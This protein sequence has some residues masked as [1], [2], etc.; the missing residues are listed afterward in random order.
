[1]MNKKLIDFGR[2]NMSQEVKTYTLE[3]FWELSEPSDGSKLELIEGILYMTPP[4]E[5]EHDIVATRINRV[6]TIELVKIKNKGRIYVPRAAIWTSPNNFLEPDLFYLSEELEKKIAHIGK[7][8]GLSHNGAKKF[9]GNFFNIMSPF[10][11]S[12]ILG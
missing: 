5:P 6:L 11:D 1:M 12:N 2:N 3:E 10:K 9:W 7:K 8:L 4:P